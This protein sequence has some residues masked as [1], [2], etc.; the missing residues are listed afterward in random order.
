MNFESFDLLAHFWLSNRSVERIEV[1]AN[2]I[3]N[4][5]PRRLSLKDFFF[6]SNPCGNFNQIL[7][8]RAD[9]YC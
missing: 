5:L 3:I 4:L 2:L 9:Y 1:I 7:A 8:L 6:M